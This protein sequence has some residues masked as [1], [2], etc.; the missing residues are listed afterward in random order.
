MKRFVL[1]AAMLAT[2]LAAACAEAPAAPSSEL[3][4]TELQDLAQSTEMSAAL[5]DQI[6]LALSFVPLGGRGG[7]SE[8]SRTQA[9]A[10]G[11]EI[12]VEGSS[13]VLTGDRA[14]GTYS[15]E[16]TATQT[17]TACAFATRDGTLVKQDGRLVVS[18]IGNVV[19][20]QLSGLQ[21]TSQKGSVAWTRG[22]ASGTCV[23]DFTTT[24]D[25]A[26]RTTT[27]KGTMCGRAVDRT[28][29][30]GGTRR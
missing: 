29:T 10:K 7:A 22:S 8:F 17:L 4:S 21:T 24:L 2:V 18:G 1:P 23:S 26:A 12:K 11:G 20:K 16:H 27:V 28:Q 30:F 3:S 15:V 25:P 9:C 19:N 14:S 13:R 5:L 6:A